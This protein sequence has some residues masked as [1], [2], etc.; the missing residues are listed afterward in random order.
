MFL[1]LLNSRQRVRGPFLIVAP[2][3]TLINWMRELSSWTH[4]DVVLYHGSQDDRDIIRQYEFMYLS[5]KPNSG[6]KVQVIVTS[7]E[8]C[9]AKD[10]SI[11][12]REL[13]KIYF[14]MLVVD[15][16]HKLKNYSS[17]VTVT[18]REEFSYRHCLLLTGTPLQV[19]FVKKSLF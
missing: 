19:N 9:L 14:E 18:L 11:G 2:L 5:R 4:L 1:E 7:P 10:S 13:S 15:E 17:K 8:T 12:G 16:A 3:S 6:Y